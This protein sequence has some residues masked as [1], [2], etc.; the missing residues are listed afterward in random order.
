MQMFPVVLRNLPGLQ[1]THDTDA[2]PV[3][4]LPGEH[5]KHSE[6]PKG[7]HECGAH[8]KHENSRF[9]RG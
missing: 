2:V 3:A 4:S 1:S 9:A 6:L 8:G 5:A 7:A